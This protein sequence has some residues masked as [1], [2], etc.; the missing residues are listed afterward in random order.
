M[1]VVGG[2]GIDSIEVN[3]EEGDEIDILDDLGCFHMGGSAIALVVPRAG[4]HYVRKD[5]EVASLC[6]YESKIKIGDNLLQ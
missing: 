5:I 2:I 6:S 1:M 4:K 3:F